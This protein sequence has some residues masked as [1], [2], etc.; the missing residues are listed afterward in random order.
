MCP[1]WD[2][3]TKRN[4][5]SDASLVSW[6]DYVNQQD[7]SL[8]EQSSDDHQGP[9][10]QDI[11][12]SPVETPE[13]VVSGDGVNMSSNH[14]EPNNI[15][16]IVLEAQCRASLQVTLNHLS[17]QGSRPQGESTRSLEF[18]SKRMLREWY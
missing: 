10:A 16:D 12:H 6:S 5:Q 8:L 2:A 18:V 4:L 14:S 11:L 7:A 13:Q 9:G 1:P 15:Q 3:E 17:G